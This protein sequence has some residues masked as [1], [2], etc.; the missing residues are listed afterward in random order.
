MA[1]ISRIIW[2]CVDAAYGWGSIVRTELAEAPCRAEGDVKPACRGPRPGN[3]PVE[4]RAVVASFSVD[5]DGKDQ[6]TDHSLGCEEGAA[7]R[8]PT[9]TGRGRTWAPG[10]GAVVATMRHVRGLRPGA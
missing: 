2:R 3:S 9:K 1:S 4:R 7:S 8:C 10:T 6:Y 5:C